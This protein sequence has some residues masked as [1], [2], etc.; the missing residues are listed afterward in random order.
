MR[1][2]WIYLM[3]LIL[4]IA[5]VGQKEDPEDIPEVPED[6]P[7]IPGG[8]AEGEVFFHRTLALCFTATWCQYCPNMEAAV[9]EVSALRPGRIIPIAIHQYD[10]ISPREAGAIVERFKVSGF[11]SMVFDL[12]PSTKFNGQSSSVILEYIDGME[13]KGTCGIALSSTAEDN[14]VTVRVSVCPAHDGTYS[15]AVA[16]VEDGIRVTQAGAGENYPCNAVL[17]MFLDG[18]ID[19]RGLGSLQAGEEKTSI[20]ECEAEAVNDNL[21]IVAY[22][23]EDGRVVNAVSCPLGKSIGYR[24]EADH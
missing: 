5:C 4:A 2:W 20:F 6:V 19:G 24:Y 16:L 14:K 15:V 1:R 3:A 18:G 17:R 22:I 10:E 7:V 9:E 23:I 11:P 12:E 8:T 13:R 21:R